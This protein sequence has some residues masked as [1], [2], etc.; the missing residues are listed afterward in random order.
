MTT[1]LTKSEFADK[2][3]LDL[4]I[5]QKFLD[6]SVYEEQCYSLDDMSLLFRVSDELERREKEEDEKEN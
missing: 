5:L 3:T 2:T 1:T 4:Q 6:Y